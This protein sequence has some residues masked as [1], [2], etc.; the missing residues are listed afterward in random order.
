MTP[1]SNQ[2]ISSLR[3]SAPKSPPGAVAPPPP[4][5]DLNPETILNEWYENCIWSSILL[6]EGHV[7]KCG[8]QHC[9]VDYA[10]L[11]AFNAL[12]PDG[13]PPWLS[14]P[15]LYSELI[16]IDDEGDTLFAFAMERIKDPP[17]SKLVN[18]H[19]PHLNAEV[20][21]TIVKGI[22]KLREAT[23]KMAHLTGLLAPGVSGL[24]PQG[25]IFPGNYLSH[26]PDEKRSWTVSTQAELADIWEAKTRSSVQ[27]WEFACGDLS[28]GNVYLRLNDQSGRL[29]HLTIADFGYAMMMPKGYDFATL[30]LNSDGPGVKYPR[31]FTDPIMRA[32]VEDGSFDVGE[33]TFRKFKDFYEQSRWKK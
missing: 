7:I 10:W 30:K 2:R 23:D 33:D 26:T 9:L 18:F 17:A 19:S 15:R 16:E 11:A 5:L 14:V 12:G 31:V 3:F 4:D 21:S 8:G 28:P 6:R 1:L 25:H 32:M 13:L 22:A 24:L 20:A 29:E 27:D